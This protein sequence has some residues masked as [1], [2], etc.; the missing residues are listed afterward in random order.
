MSDT[1]WLEA[2]TPYGAD[3]PRAR[4][5]S[6]AAVLDLA[7]Q[8]TFSYSPAR[9]VEAEPPTRIEVPGCWQ[10]Q[11][12]G[13]PVYLSA[14]LPFAMDPP[15][16]PDDSAIGTYRREVDVPEGFERAVLRCDGID[17]TGEISV[18]GKRVGWTKGSRLTHEFGLSLSPGRHVV[19]IRVSQYSATSYV[20]DQDMFWLSGIFRDIAL[21]AR[22]ED[23]IDDVAV[24]ADYDPETGVGLLQFDVSSTGTVHAA[25]DGLPV[26]SGRTELGPVEPWT[27]ETPR[28]YE[29]VVSTGAETVTMRVGFRRVEIS[30]GLLRVNGHP[31]RFR[32]VNRH[33]TDP[34]H[35]RTVTDEQ[36][37]A[38]LLAMKR[39]N[40]NAVRTSHY[41][42]SPALLDVA[43]E[44]GLY[45][46]EENDI[47][48]HAFTL[49]GWRRNP[50]DDPAWREA[51]L[52]RTAR[53]VRRDGNH[54]C[55]V[56]WSLG[57]EAGPGQNFA[58]VRDW[59]REN[60]PTRPIHYERDPSYSCS[61]VFSVMYPELDRLE[62]MAK[63]DEEPSDKPI[64][65]CEYAH[66][67]GAGPGGFDEYEALF[68][69]YPRLQGGFVW[70]WQDHTLR[71]PDG[72][73]GYGG[74]FGEPLHDG[75]FAAD[76][77]RFGDGRPKPGLYDYAHVVSPVRLEVAETWDSVLVTNRYDHV[78]LE[79]VRLT[80]S[81]DDAGGTVANGELELP[82]VAP[83]ESATVP[84][85]AAALR[86]D[87]AV[88]SV[89]AVSAAGT[90]WAPAGHE[91]GWGQAAR[92][93]DHGRLPAGRAG[94]DDVSFNDLGAL[95][96][97]GGYGVRGPRLGLWRAPTDN[98]WGLNMRRL[99][100]LSDEE[101]WRS[102]NLAHLS[103]RTGKVVRT[104]ECVSVETWVAPYS[105]SFGVH[106][107]LA[108]TPATGGASLRATLEPYG[109][110]S[111][112][113][114]RCGLDWVL[115]DLGGDAVV[116]WT[117]RGPGRAGADVGQAARWGW[118]ESTVDAWQVE[119]A[120]PQDDGL[121]GGVT[122][123]S[124]GLPD[125]RRLC[126]TSEQPLW[127]SLRPWTDAHV[128]AAGHP[129]E[130]PASSSLVLSLNAAVNG[131][132]TG[133]CGPGVQPRYALTPR[134]VELSISVTIL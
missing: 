134:P 123:L 9:G 95:V 89:S 41:P 17:A 21:V 101:Q 12:H 43:D 122:E 120:R 133:A 32:G 19:E 121:R 10:L 108:W 83:G 34:D 128:A 131:Y 96:G 69:T 53:M 124:L 57:N 56:M 129:D 77:L 59:L 45:V 105:R 2:L 6:D 78:G 127:V 99:G 112:T 68:D 87:R 35:G 80:W 8:W 55:V 118:F 13:S 109:E 66:A 15:H 79:S 76:G 82:V 14:Q 30:D 125:R 85:P 4:V 73:L 52:D 40:I 42:P 31:I 44:L 100:Q 88:L 16:V 102:S 71:L 54:A 63:G 116:R 27:A 132:G 113:W 111:T 50:S 7:G 49:D 28:L 58:S 98:D 75:A 60:D 72:R 5:A 90:A 37:R 107:R 11:G 97:I 39:A 114:A 104:P 46:L 92:G 29:L 48:T 103:Q 18:D 33:D 81:V 119:H 22:P 74:D 67:M 84:V 130:L 24:V 64:I 62:R 86:R 61:D 106:S 94:F 110:W 20:E 91:V 38:D 36:V 25:L 65:L 26:A 70:E 115:P 117:G 1:Q 93:L 47:E 3:P 51:Y 23:G 126:V